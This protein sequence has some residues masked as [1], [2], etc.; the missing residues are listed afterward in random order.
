MTDLLNAQIPRLCGCDVSKAGSVAFQIILTRTEISCFGIL[1]LICYVWFSVNFEYHRDM[2]LLKTARSMQI[3]KGLC[4]YLV[5]SVFNLYT[6]NSMF[7]PFLLVVSSSSFLHFL[8]NSL[9]NTVVSFP[10][11]LSVPFQ[12]L[13]PL[14]DITHL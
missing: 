4:F 11:I 7:Y 9:L 8:I 13:T 6:S 5:Q 1:T 10:K 2:I 3:V 14:Q 12:C